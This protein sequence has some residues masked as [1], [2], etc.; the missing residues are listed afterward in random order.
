MP[1]LTWTGKDQAVIA[2]RGVP[3]RLLEPHAAGVSQGQPAG[4]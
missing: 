3:F 2:A 4:V 1:T